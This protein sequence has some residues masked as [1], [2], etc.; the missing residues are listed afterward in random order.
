[1]KRG[2]AL[3]LSSVAIG[4]VGI[5]WTSPPAV[6]KGPSQGII[7]GPGLSEPITLREPGA[8]TIGPD[9][10][11]VV[12]QSGFFVG[13]GGGDRDRLARRPAGD[14]GPRYTITY[15][16]TLSDRDSGTIVQYVYPYAEP[17]PITYMPAKQTYWGTKTVGAW[18]AA[19]VGFR[20]TLIDVGLPASASPQPAAG[21]DA[22][23]SA[24]SRPAGS[25]LTGL[26]VATVFLALALVAI[27]MRRNRLPL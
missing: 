21:S 16:M 7:T 15:S 2:L 4:V 20:Q 27:L 24:V 14:L 25:I 8:A 6:A 11:G 5:L 23:P 3:A 17:L 1:M 9:L 22:G 26:V 10:A 12:E 13:L 18:Y 19:R